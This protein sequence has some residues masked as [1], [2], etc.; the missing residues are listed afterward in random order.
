LARS[1]APNFKPFDAVPIARLNLAY[2]AV[3]PVS[4]PW[5]LGTGSQQVV[6]QNNRSSLFF[7]NLSSTATVFVCPAQDGNNNPLSAG[8]PGSIPIPPGAGLPIEET[9][10]AW[11]AAASAPNTPFTAL[12]FFVGGITGVIGFGSGSTPIPP[13]TLLSNDGGWLIVS[14]AAGWPSSSVALPAGALWSNGALATVVP[15]VTPDPSAPGVFFGSITAAALLALGGGNLPLSNPGPG[16]GQ[17]WNQG[18]VV[19]I[20]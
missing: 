5:I 8:G 19:A 18:G 10:S 13:T 9:I 6:G 16:S 2:Q 20:A 1:Q 12:E 15:G 11:N 14:N 4:W 17:L 3:S 7:S